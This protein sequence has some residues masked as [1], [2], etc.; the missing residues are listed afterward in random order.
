MKKFVF[1]ILPFLAM[2]AVITS[3]TKKNNNTDPNEKFSTL[4]VEANKAIVENAGID[5]IAVLKRL[6]DIQ[7]VDVLLNLGDITSSSKNTVL[8]K[9]SK[10]LSTFSTFTAAAKGETKMNNLFKSLVSPKELAQDYQSIKE[11]WDSNVGTYTWNPANNDWTIALGGT[12]IIM[13]FP[14]TDVSTTNDATLTISN[15]AGIIVNNPIDDNYT[16]DFPVALNADLKVGTKTLITYVFSAQYNS[17]GIPSAVASDL[18]IEN[19]KFEADI[20]NDTKIVSV[21]YKFLENDVV[22]MNLSATGKGLFTQAN[23]NANTTTHTET[24]SYISDFVWNS[25]T[26]QWD[27]V[28]STYTDQWD[29]TEFEE[30]INSSIVEFRLSNIALRGDCDI[31]GLTDQIR[32]I[33]IDR[34]NQVITSANADSLYTIQINKFLNLKLVNVTSNEIIAKAN[35]YVVKEINYGDVDTYINF[36]LT[37]KDGSPID[38]DTY[39][40]SGFDN[41][42]TELNRLID[43][44]NSEYDLG[45]ETVDY[46][47]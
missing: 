8:T 33:Q 44:I 22:V 42:V 34:D 18:T 16:G 21:S 1:M 20:T 38:L 30:I 43:D 31:K 26:Q 11:F 6:K 9:G 40:N 13:K 46:K 14:S 47:K 10:L 2:I 27:P 7:T 36:R 29:E 4:S 17:D 41:F 39:T 5:F 32:L 28:Y 15:Y 19:Y 24:H 37:F 35:A 23:Y 3:C 45:I 25:S 12:T